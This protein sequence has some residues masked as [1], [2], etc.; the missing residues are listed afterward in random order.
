MGHFWDVSEITKN[1]LNPASLFCKLKHLN[2]VEVIAMKTNIIYLV[3]FLMFIFSACSTSKFGWET[4]P[5]TDKQA[6][7][8]KEGIVEDFDPLSLNEE[9]VR[10]TPIQEDQKV[11]QISMP[12]ETSQEVSESEMVAGYRVQLFAA[13]NKDNASE[14]Q[15]R[16]IF[17]FDQRVDMIFLAPNYKV[18]V[19]EFIDLKDARS[20]AEEAKRQ[21]FPDAWP[22]PSKV[23]PNNVPKKY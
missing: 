3:A 16:A 5:N 20:F 11:P 4:E 22:V 15:R 2:R 6:S 13:V 23:N 19:G 14:V 21:G 18:L 12:S 8:S 7:E 9:D 1:I 10:V 17:K